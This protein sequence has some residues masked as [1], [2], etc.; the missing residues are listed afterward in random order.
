MHKNTLKKL[1]LALT[2]WLALNAAA[3][4]AQILGPYGTSPTTFEVDANALLWDT[5]TFGTGTLS[6][7][8]AGT[9]M[10]WYP[11]KASFRAGYVNGTQW[12][13][14]YIGLYSVA[15]GYN[16]IAY[17]NESVAI[18]V[19]DTAS[20]Y[21][22]SAFGAFNTASG[23][24]SM[25]VGGAVSALGLGSTASGLYNTATGYG[26]TAMGGMNT[27]SGNYSLATGHHTLTDA[28]LS[29]TIGTYNVGGGSAT[30]WVST[31]PIF[32]IGNGTSTTPSDAVVIYKNGNADFQ[33]AITA[34]PA[35]DIP[36]YTGN[37]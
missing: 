22:S 26:A 27:A 8:G 3:L 17:G 34:A 28:Y 18:G 2:F 33:G 11:G 29:F 7:S 21:A 36:M 37:N 24:A 14:S 30:T 12:N 35:G 4:K 31:D 19:S 15:L 9:R 16:T 23:T 1:A 5:G 32:E 6:L 10:F 20:G 25:A 13:D